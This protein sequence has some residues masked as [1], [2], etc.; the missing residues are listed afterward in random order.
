MNP[1]LLAFFAVLCV[2]PI[3]AVSGQAVPPNLHGHIERRCIECH[4]KD[5]AKGGLDLTAQSFDLNDKSVRERWIQIHDRIEKAGHQRNTEH[6]I[7]KLKD[8]LS[9]RA[10]IAKGDTGGLPRQSVQVRQLLR[11]LFARRGVKKSP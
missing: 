10:A 2:L 4:D 5:T 3:S 9:L 6:A 11:I 7:K 8:A 1:T